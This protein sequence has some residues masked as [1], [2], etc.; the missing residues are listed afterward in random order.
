[1]LYASAVAD[2]DFRTARALKSGPLWVWDQTFTVDAVG[3]CS[4]EIVE[5]SALALGSDALVGSV[6]AGTAPQTYIISR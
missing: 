2:Q 3:T 5:A 6:T 1:M 4:F